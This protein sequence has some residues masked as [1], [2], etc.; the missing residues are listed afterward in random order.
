MSTWTNRINRTIPPT[1]FSWVLSAFR[2][3]AGGLGW[4]PWLVGARTLLG[5][6][7]LTTSNKKLL[8]APGIATRS[9]DAR[10]L[11]A[12]GIICPIDVIFF[13]YK[14]CL[15]G[16]Q[17]LMDCFEEDIKIIYLKDVCHVL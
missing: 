3:E 11:E 9:K 6:P 2:L 1:D 14:Q 7:G 15:S 17:A 10:G 4:R 12:M 8:G 5:A 13:W 16:N